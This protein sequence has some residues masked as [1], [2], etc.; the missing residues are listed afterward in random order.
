MK[1][2]GFYQSL[3]FILSILTVFIFKGFNFKC[4]CLSVEN[5]QLR[6]TLVILASVRWP[7]SAKQ[8]LKNRT[9]LIARP[10]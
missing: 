3:E 10:F 1:C 2:V 6:N 8:K 7:F 4:F 9:E 5:S